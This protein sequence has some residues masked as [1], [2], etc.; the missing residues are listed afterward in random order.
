M[1]VFAAL[2][3]SAIYLFSGYIVKEYL[4]PSFEDSLKIQMQDFTHGIDK[5]MITKAYNGDS[6][7]LSSLQ[8]Y[9]NQYKKENDVANAYILGKKQDQ[10]FIVAISDM[11]DTMVDY[12]FVPEMTAAIGG[13]SALSDIYSDEYGTYKSYFAPIDGVNAIFGLD[14]DA[15][16][17][18]QLKNYN[19]I[20]TLILGGLM[21]LAGIAMAWIISKMISKPIKT[22]SAH[23][24]VVAAGNLSVA[25]LNQNRNDELGDLAAHFNQMVADLRTMILEV[26]SQSDHVASTSEEL[27]ASAEETSQS[28]SEASH[29]VQQISMA[30]SDQQQR[31]VELEDSSELLSTHMQ[32]LTKET[33]ATSQLSEDAADVANQGTDSIR[34]AIDQMTII[35]ENVSKSADVVAKLHTESKEIADIVMTISA[36]AEQTNLLALNASI[37]AARAGA[38]GQGFAVVAEEVRKLAEESSKAASEIQS[39][40]LQ[41]QSQAENSVEVMTVG[42]TATK[43]GLTAI[44]EANDAFTNILSTT[45]QS[46]EKLASIQEPLE[47]MN[48]KIQTNASTIKEVTATTNEMFERI[49]GISE[50]SEEQTAVVQEIASASETLSSMAEDLQLTIQKFNTDQVNPEVLQISEADRKSREID[51]KQAI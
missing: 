21:L 34:T 16:F 1:L 39:K 18:N 25:E 28:I 3:S 37:E 7:A 17:I 15:G 13:E 2:F 49:K 29:M 50:T 19:L 42:Y 30:S 32:E 26:G 36:I 12:D 47:E 44:N 27:S 48:K 14:K 22:I 51:Q 23:A 38:E 46:R 45:E 9:L 35:D 40:T 6:Q 20:L 31:L 33:A 5:E 10:T 43:S 41:I 8:Q 11:E 24:E 4:Q